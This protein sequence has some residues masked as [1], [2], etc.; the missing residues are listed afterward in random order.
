MSS[1]SGIKSPTEGKLWGFLRDM[2]DIESLPCVYPDVRTAKSRFHILETP[3]VTEERYSQSLH[4]L[5]AYAGKL[6]FEAVRIRFYRLDGSS[7]DAVV[8]LSDE[9]VS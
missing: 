3:S 2:A 5:L 1:M 7:I 9:F 4:E 8:V 6:G